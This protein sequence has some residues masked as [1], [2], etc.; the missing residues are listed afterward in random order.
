[1]IYFCADKEDVQIISVHA[2]A[3]VMIIVMYY[4]SDKEDINS[5]AVQGMMN[6]HLHYQVTLEQLDFSFGLTLMQRLSG[7]A[8]NEFLLIHKGCVREKYGTIC[9][10]SHQEADIL[11]LL[12][13]CHTKRFPHRHER[14][15]NT[16][17]GHTIGHKI[18]HT[19]GCYF[20]KSVKSEQFKAGSH[21]ED[22]ER[23][24]A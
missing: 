21:R 10:C 23:L 6:A 18:G 19:I 1:M 12:S 14:H 2:L 9:L 17:I 4:C 20:W 24:E 8:T 16:K 22:F 5:L 15:R 3:T 13:I 11:I 7:H